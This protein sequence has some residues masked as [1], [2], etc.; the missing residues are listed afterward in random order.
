MIET[1]EQY[2]RLMVEAC[3][4]ILRDPDPETADGKRL[5]RITDEIM[6]YEKRMFPELDTESPKFG[7]WPEI[8]TC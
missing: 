5:T 6:A 8:P 2:N 4:L 7:N 1:E 3:N